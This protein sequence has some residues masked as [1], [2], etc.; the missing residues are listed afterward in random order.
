MKHNWLLTVAVVGQWICLGLA[1]VKQPPAIQEAFDMAT[2]TLCEE[3]S[4]CHT[5]VIQ[6]D[7]CERVVT[8]D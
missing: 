4:G 1:A 7:D 6:Y 5:V 3:E 8:F 2:V